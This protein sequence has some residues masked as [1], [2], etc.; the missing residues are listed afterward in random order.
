MPQE[1]GSG[2]LR[3][4]DKRVGT[5]AL[6]CGGSSPDNTPATVSCCSREL[7]PRMMARESSTKPSQLPSNGS[8]APS[9]QHPRHGMAPPTAAAPHIHVQAPS[10]APARSLTSQ[11]PRHHAAKV[12]NE[13]TVEPVVFVDGLLRE[14]VGDGATAAVASGGRRRRWH[15][16]GAATGAPQEARAR[17][18]RSAQR[19][20]Q[21]MG[22]PIAGASAVFGTVLL[23]REC[24]CAERCGAR[25]GAHGCARTRLR[26][27]CAKCIT[28]PGVDVGW[29]A[30]VMSRH[31]QHDGVVGPAL[32][33]CGTCLAF[34]AWFTD[35]F[36]CW[37]CSLAEKSSLYVKGRGKGAVVGVPCRAAGTREAQK[38][39]IVM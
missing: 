35:Q 1:Q 30:G 21:M 25:H 17:D 2:S 22:S 3:A 10:A 37:Q 24:S 14:W 12:P 8:P 18:P 36:R 6:A 9:R 33:H 19:C 11:L 13:R 38:K 16:G 28:P 27:Q 20:R 15:G 29:R 26:D 23:R 7:R 5:A 32:T 34:D 4:Q 39:A 31:P